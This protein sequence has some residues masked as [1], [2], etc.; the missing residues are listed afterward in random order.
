MIKFLHSKMDSSIGHEC[1]CVSAVRVHH[2]DAVVQIEG[3]VL[4]L[5]HA[6]VVL[7]GN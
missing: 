3:F 1:R 2:H 6:S 7:L 4:A 5:C